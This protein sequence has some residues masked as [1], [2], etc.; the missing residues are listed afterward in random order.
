MSFSVLGEISQVIFFFISLIWFTVISNLLL[1]DPLWIQNRLPY[2]FISLQ[3]LLTYSSLLSFHRYDVS[4]RPEDTN[5]RLSNIFS[6]FLGAEAVIE[7]PQECSCIMNIF[8]WPV[9]S[10]IFLVTDK[11]KT[12]IWRILC[13]FKSRSLKGQSST[14]LSKTIKSKNCLN[15]S[16]AYVVGFLILN[17]Y[18]QIIKIFSF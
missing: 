16:Y 15:F 9:I 2:F 13:T 1:I 17:I 4:F 12:V 3:L 11:G 5:W 14:V 18:F 8:I 7:I 6:H 10:Y